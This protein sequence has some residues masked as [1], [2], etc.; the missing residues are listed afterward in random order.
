MADWNPHQYLRFADERSQPSIDLTARIRPLK[1][2]RKILDIGCGPGN[3]THVL[4]QKFPHACIIGIDSSENM[5]QVAKSTSVDLDADLDFMICDAATGL[6]SLET[7]YDIVFSNAAV[8]WIP[9]HDELLRNMIGR[10]K[11]GGI[12]AVQTPLLEKH[13]F[14]RVIRSVVNHA[15]YKGTFP[16][17]IQRKNNLS[18][19]EYAAIL[20]D[21]ADTF[22]I[23]ETVY[24][25]VLPSHRDI[26]EWF[27]ATRLRPYFSALSPDRVPEFEADLLEAFTQSIP[28]TKSG[29]I[30]MPFPRLF[31]TAVR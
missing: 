11:P 4:A 30:L 1:K 17:N 22:D 5:I 25:H 27:R 20:T 31:F 21:I 28:A 13:P 24:Y 3:S 12:L 26:V 16:K 2:P 6:P 18:P 8:Q 9:R 15:K 29:S 7:N 23:W 19:E 14:H 10:L